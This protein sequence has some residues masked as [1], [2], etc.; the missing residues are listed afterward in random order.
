M[1]VKAGVHVAAREFFQVSLV[2][3]LLLTLAETLRTGVVSNFFNL[4]YLLIVVV[5][6][7]AVMVVTEPA[8]VI[9]KVAAEILPAELQRDIGRVVRQ[10]R[11]SV[12]GIV[13]KFDR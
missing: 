5:V 10:T 1:S 9:A 11:R 6:S 2:T 12:D 7:G 8:E 13:R 3:Y 4:N